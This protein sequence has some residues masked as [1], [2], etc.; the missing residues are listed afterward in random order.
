MLLR[1][2]RP[3]KILYL[4]LLKFPGAEG[5]ITRSYL[6]AKALTNL[7]NPKGEFLPGNIHNIKEIDEYP[8]GGLRAK[9]DF[10]GSISY[11]AKKSFQHKI[12]SHRFFRQRI[13]TAW[14][15]SLGYPITSAGNSG[16]KSLKINSCFAKLFNRI[17]KE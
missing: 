3:D 8:L 7:G 1:F 10:L 13:P 9:I 11:R 16:H 17:A 4:H 14:T 6:I 2:L 5:D 15:R 12:C